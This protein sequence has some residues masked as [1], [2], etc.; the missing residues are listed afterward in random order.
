MQ[1]TKFEGNS[2]PK[3]QYIVDQTYTVTEIKL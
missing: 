3:S 2:I 1:T